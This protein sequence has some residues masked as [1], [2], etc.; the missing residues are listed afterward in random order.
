MCVAV[1][2]GPVFSE[3]PIDVRNT[4]LCIVEVRFSLHWTESKSA[5]SIQGS[6][7]DSP[8]ASKLLCALKEEADSH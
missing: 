3:T 4:F 7:P 6:W 5:P 1:A 2:A 8:I